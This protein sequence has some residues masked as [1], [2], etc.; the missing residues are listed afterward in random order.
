MS[1]HPLLEKAKAVLQ[2]NWRQA[3]TIPSPHLYPFQW[4]WDAGFII[5]GWLQVDH[6]KAM[7]EFRSLFKGQ[8]ANGFLP[9]IIFHQ[10]VQDQ[11]FPN[12]DFWAS[13]DSNFAPQ[14]LKTSGIT[15]PPVHGFVL[16]RFLAKSKGAAQLSFV[17]EAF[18]QVHQLHRYY[19]ENRDPNQEGLVYICHPWESGRDNS[20]IWNEVYQYW[21]LDPKDVPPYQRVA[22]ELAKAKERPTEDDYNRYVYL[23]GLGRK[24]QY[25][26]L[27][28]Q[29]SS[30][31]LVQDTLFN[32]ILIESNASLIR[33]GQI[34]GI[35]VKDLM[36]WQE[37]AIEQFN[38][39]LWDSHLQC[40]VPFDLRNNNPI[41][42]REIGGLLAL[43]A[44]IPHQ[45]RAKELINTLL[46]PAFL[47]NEKE[48]AYLCPT[49]DKTHP[50]FEGHKYWR[51][52]VWINTNWMLYHGLKRY[53]RTSLAQ[54]IK[55]DSL[56]LIE[57]LGIYEYFD[58]DKAI[59]QQQNKAYGSNDFSWT[60]ALYLDLISEES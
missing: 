10:E 20:P 21:P 60:A 19:Y 7:Q 38:R 49:F 34:L 1:K 22:Q 5:L 3:Y 35:D 6:D 4:N 46:S 55:K 12:A 16:E 18:H 48:Q 43:F 47:V 44:G 59:T 25:Q 9:H 37:T 17:E 30:P 28:I 33:I 23:L 15:Q 8:W 26:D 31:F 45:K 57:K 13:K 58:A 51:G 14:N 50:A 52:P 53:S 29:K 39:K 24:H 40:Y 41:R 11:Y 32:S 2:A 54:N 42:V 27:P 56:E 36:N